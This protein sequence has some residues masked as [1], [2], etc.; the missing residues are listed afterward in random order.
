ML[1]GWLGAA[2]LAFVGER[3]F[4]WLEPIFLSRPEVFNNSIL[5]AGFVIVALFGWISLPMIG[6]SMGF[7]CASFWR[8]LPAKPDKSYVGHAML[9]LGLAQLPIIHLVGWPAIP[10]LIFVSPLLISPTR[11]GLKSGLKWQ[12]ADGARHFL[13]LRNSWERDAG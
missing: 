4:H 2:V 13:G 3:L 9:F 5:V 10:A 1:V 7:I 12:I 6:F 11:L 8:H